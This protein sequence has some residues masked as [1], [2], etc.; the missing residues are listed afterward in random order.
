LINFEVQ[1]KFLSRFSYLFF[2]VFDCVI[3][4]FVDNFK[5][6]FSNRKIQEKILKI[7]TP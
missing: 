3:Y 1:N 5:A 2:I 4:G 6:V 7:L